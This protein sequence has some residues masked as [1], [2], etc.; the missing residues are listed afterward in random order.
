MQYHYEKEW[1]TM[2]EFDEKTSIIKRKKLQ[3]KQ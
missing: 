2:D 1:K 3:Y